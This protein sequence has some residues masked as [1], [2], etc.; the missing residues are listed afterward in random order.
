M[1][2]E[3]CD[4]VNILNTMM[5]FSLLAGDNSAVIG[6][7]PLLFKAR[8]NTCLEYLLLLFVLSV[9]DRAR[10]SDMNYIFVA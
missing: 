9:P 7:D 1:N 8:V 5:G 10:T 3:G 2:E 4:L 6:Q